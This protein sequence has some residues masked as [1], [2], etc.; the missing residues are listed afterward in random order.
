[1][2]SGSLEYRS[3]IDVASL[4]CGLIRIRRAVSICVGAFTNHI[5]LR[6]SF[7]YCTIEVLRRIA[8]GGIKVIYLA[9]CVRE[10]LEQL[11]FR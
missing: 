6:R 1:M 2:T 3:K 11:P 9:G 7:A 10:S 4:G 8:A 5:T